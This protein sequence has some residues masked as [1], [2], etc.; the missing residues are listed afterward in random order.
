MPP[1][2][3]TWFFVGLTFTTLLLAVGHWAPWNLS[4]LQAYTYGVACLLAGFALWQLMAGEWQAVAGMVAL[5]A[6][7]GGTVWLGYKVDALARELRK[8]KKAEENDDEL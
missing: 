7:G 1:Q 5:A 4:Q 2:D 6:I 8:A 3:L